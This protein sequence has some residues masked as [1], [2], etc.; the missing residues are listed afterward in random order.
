MFKILAKSRK[1]K[2]RTAVIYTARGKV[3]T[4]CFMPIA[5]SGA[6]KTLTSDDLR[7]LKAAMILANTYH[8]ACKPGM[9]VLRKAGGLHKFM[10]WQ[11]PILTDSGGYQVFSLAKLRKISSAGVEFQSH[12]GGMKMFLTPAKAIKI[13]KIIGSDIMMALDVCAPYPCNFDS[14]EKAVRQT[15]EWAEKSLTA[16]KRPLN[17][18]KRPLLFGIIQGSVF[19]Q[20]RRKSCQEITALDFDGFAIG[21]LAVGEPR[22]KMTEILK[23]TASFLPEEKPR[24]LMGVGKPDEL[25]QA[26]QEG[27]DMFDCV[28]PTR[29]ARHGRIY[30]NFKK[31]YKIIQI[32]NMKFKNDLRPLD[33]N[34]VCYTCQNYSRAYLRHLFSV[35]EPLASRLA[36]IHNLHFYLH[37]MEMI[38]QKIKLGNL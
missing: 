26:V 33:E 7:E 30:I 10:N 24:Y 25:L 14:A 31:N 37:W 15:T 9:A 11:G 4:P 3:P 6:V 36:T 32:T 8:L 16:F 35:Q 12:F 18:K 20:L 17:I 19:K 38:R 28:I 23:Y 27:I 2:A 5:T 13:Q 21:G 34:C 22:T 29:E 1:S